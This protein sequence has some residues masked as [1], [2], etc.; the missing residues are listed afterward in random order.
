M[1]TRGHAHLNEKVN[2]YEGSEFIQPRSYSTPSTDLL[3]F[4]MLANLRLKL[5]SNNY[6][7][8]LRSIVFHTMVKYFYE[9]LTD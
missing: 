5:L 8:E 1:K 7:Y 2:L 9:I 3:F 4:R 6:A